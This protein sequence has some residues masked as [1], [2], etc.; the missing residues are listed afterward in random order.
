MKNVFSIVTHAIRKN[1]I[2]GMKNA[3]TW[4]KMKHS[5]QQK[6]QDHSRRFGVLVYFLNPKA[7]RML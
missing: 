7:A 2:P 5:A 1:N 3:K 6:R 4:N